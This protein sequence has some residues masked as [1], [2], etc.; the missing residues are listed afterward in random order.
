LPHPTSRGG[1]HKSECHV[2]ASK[3][4]VRFC[5]LRELCINTLHDALEEF[6]KRN[7]FM[8]DKGK[9]TFKEFEGHVIISSLELNVFRFGRTSDRVFRGDDGGK[10]VVGHGRC[11]KK[12]MIS[13]NNLNLSMDYLRNL[14]S[15]LVQ[16]SGLTLPF[17]L[18]QKVATCEGL[19]TLYDAT[20]RVS[21]FLATLSCCLTMHRTMALLSLSLNMTSAIP[22]DAT[23]DHL[24]R[25]L[26]RNSER[27]DTQMCSNSWTP[28]NRTP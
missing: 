8:I 26:S 14:G 5:H 28:S 18:G 4:Y 9:F 1:W 7:L 10:G 21:V 13:I 23:S 24:L 11:Q 2:A 17:S 6:T 27:Q 3:E 12:S 16:K 15:A 22:L 25:T 19:Y 20:K